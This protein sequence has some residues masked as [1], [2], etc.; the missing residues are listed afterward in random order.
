MKGLAIEVAQRTCIG[1]RSRNEDCVAVV[2]QGDHWCLVLSDG[3]GGHG[4]GAR[5]SQLAVGRVLLGFRSRPPVDCRDLAELLLDA[6]DTLVASQPEGPPRP[7]TAMYATVV[8]LVIDTAKRM[9]LC[10]HVGDSRLYQWRARRLNTVTRDDSA[11]QSLLDTGLVKHEQV[12]NRG[13]LLAA[14]GAVEE[15]EPH[16]S[17]FELQ[18]QDAFLLCT[19]GW[20]AGLE[21]EL[22]SA[23]LA[24]AAAPQEWLEAMMAHTRKRADPRQDNYSAIACWISESLE[25][26]E[27]EC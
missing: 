22:I 27:A 20:W 21:P 13:V 2:S 26:A 5:A 7:A 9:A 18:S 11:L 8:V 24:D 3:A 23:S 17:E 4:E 14:L 12:A 25:A 10:G 19:D 15:V 1:A 16:V 6:H